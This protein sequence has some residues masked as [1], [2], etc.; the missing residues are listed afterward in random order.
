MILKTLFITY[1]VFCLYLGY[2]LYKDEKDNKKRL[3][4][5]KAILNQLDYQGGIVTKELYLQ[6]LQNGIYNEDFEKFKK[7]K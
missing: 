5:Y 1:L 7:I 4:S 6:Y 3:Q 2:L